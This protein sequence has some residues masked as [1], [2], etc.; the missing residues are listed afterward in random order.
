MRCRAGVP[1]SHSGET[2]SV[3]RQSLFREGGGPL[4]PQLKLYPNY[5]LARGNLTWAWDPKDT[6][7]TGSGDSHRGQPNQEY[8]GR[9]KGTEED[10]MC[11]D[12]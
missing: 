10:R 11:S 4:G 6:P 1:R 9:D 7:R 5:C 12:A 2:G 8:K 3:K